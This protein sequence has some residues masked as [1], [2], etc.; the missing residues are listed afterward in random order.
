MVEEILNGLRE[1]YPGLSDFTLGKIYLFDRMERGE[2]SSL[3]LVFLS[4]LY[5]QITL[6]QF[7]DYLEIQTGC[8]GC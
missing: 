7:L 4:L 2:A 5:G 6:K 8:Q 3:E 1:K